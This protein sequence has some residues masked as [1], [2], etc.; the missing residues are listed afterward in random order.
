MNEV[1][2]SEL[3]PREHVGWL[4]FRPVQYL[5]SKLRVLEEIRY[6]AST[7]IAPGGTVADLFTGT[8][9]VAQQLALTGSR[10]SAVDTQRYGEIFG[11]AMLGIERDRGESVDSGKIV[12]FAREQPNRT[13]AVWERAAVQEK[14]AIES[15]D[16]AALRNL[17][18]TLPLAWRH[19]PYS[20]L[21]NSICS[22]YAG[23]YFGV[24]QAIEIDGLRESIHA[25]AASGLLSEWQKAAAM[26]GLMHAA[27]MSVHSA[28]KHFAQPLGQGAGDSRFLNAR[29]LSDR[30]ISI[31]ECFKE[32][33]RR[34]SESPFFASDSHAAHRASAESFVRA[35]KMGHDL[36]Y[37]DPP[38]TAQQYSRFYHVLETLADDGSPK[39][40]PGEIQSTGLYPVGRYKS[41]F[42]S[43]RMAPGAMEA[44]V[45]EIARR[46]SAALISYSASASGSDGNAR[47]VTLEEL[48]G[49]CA[50]AFGRSGVEC[51]RMAHRYRQFNRADKANKQRD[52]SEILILCKSV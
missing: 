40:P 25:M 14:A 48:L 44:L 9:V 42:S 51:L 1:I 47:M 33:S 26:T 5:G 10:V 15:A 12:D 46:G 6:A 31:V 30:S 23:T 22:V 7:L 43:R 13:T 50:R 28:G 21:P 45:N 27:S 16:A 17:Y 2:A 37:L 4:P 11:S 39:L 8:T 52:D 3:L 35:E 19:N 34:V 32:G 49:F 36:Y 20:E 29:L 18:E 41:A 24:S 38:Y